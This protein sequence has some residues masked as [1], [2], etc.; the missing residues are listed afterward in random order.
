[1][2]PEYIEGVGDCTRICDLSGESVSRKKLQS[3][4][5]EL[6]RVKLLDYEGIKYKT[7]KFL[8]QKNLN[9]LYLG[10]EEILIPVK[11]R[12]PM[13]LKDGTYG[14]I[15]V[16]EI[17]KVLDS[18][19]ILKDNGR[20]FFFETKRIIARRMKMA[21]ALREVFG[22][23]VGFYNSKNQLDSGILHLIEYVF[24]ELTN[25]KLIMER[26]LVPVGG[27]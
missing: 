25:I 26:Y 23:D 24:K 21:R 12:K 18:E 10:Q 7:S 2:L 4:I 20:I 1:M 5:K 27:I 9:P 22:M 19:I 14:Y 16:F 11:I 17:N 8:G 13:V 6:Y 3:V 15:N